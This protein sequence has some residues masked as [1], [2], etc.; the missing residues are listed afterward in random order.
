RQIEF[1][2]R[3]V[4]IEKK[5]ADEAGFFVYKSFFNTSNHVGN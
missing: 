5:P 4:E 2:V 1:L 3:D